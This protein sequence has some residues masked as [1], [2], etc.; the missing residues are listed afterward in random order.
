MP[1][2]SR[3]HLRNRLLNLMVDEDFARL[4]SKLDFVELPKHSMLATADGVTDDLFFLESGLGSIVAASPEGQE[5]EAGLFGFEGFCPT[6]TLLGSQTTPN[7]ITMQI[8]G[9]GYRIAAAFLLDAV[10]RSAS[11]RGLLLR[12]TQALNVQTTFTALSNAVHSVDERL[13]RWLLMS[14]DRSESDDVPLTH[15]FLSIML[16]VRRPSVTTALHVLEGNGF[17]TTERGQ[18]LIRNR[19][20]LEDFARDAYGKPEAEYLRLI[21]PMR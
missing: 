12:Y 19:K 13:A 3:A 10:E 20:G 5:V 14:H 21:G 17:I 18:I 11:L 6:S 8:G 7:M 9:G 4:G 16:A 2:L 1:V 15:D